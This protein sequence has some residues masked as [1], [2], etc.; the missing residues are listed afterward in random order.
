MNDDREEN[1]NLS[2]GR[3]CRRSHSIYTALRRMPDV[4]VQRLFQ[5]LANDYSGPL[6]ILQMEPE[7]CA[8]IHRRRALR[9]WRSFVR[10]AQMAGTG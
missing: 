1:K 8:S 3:S 5:H 10:M 4:K 7:P 9:T 2:E 6:E